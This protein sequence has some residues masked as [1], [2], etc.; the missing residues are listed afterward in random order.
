MDGA[1]HLQAQDMSEGKGG[2]YILEGDAYIYILSSTERDPSRPLN[3]AGRVRVST[4]PET[5]A[6]YPFLCPTLSLYSHIAP[7]PADFIL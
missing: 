4:I 5:R 7:Q 1:A 3:S 2:Q 6:F